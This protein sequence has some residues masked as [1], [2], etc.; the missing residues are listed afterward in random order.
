MDETLNTEN[1]ENIP[2]AAG[3]NNADTPEQ[4]QKRTYPK[5]KLPKIFRK[6]Y[7]EKALKRKIVKPI[8]IPLDKEF[9]QGI[10]VKDGDPKK[11]GKF[12]VPNDK[13]FSKKEIS[14][15]RTLA[16]DIQSRKGRFMLLPFAAVIGFF[17]LLCMLFTA[18]KNPLLK[19]ALTYAA[20]EAVGAKVDIGSVNLKILDAELTI[21]NV[22]VGN[23]KEVMKN[24]AQFDKLDV[25]FNLAQAL[26]GKFD[27]KNLEVTGI[28]LNTNRT[29]SCELPESRKKKTEEKPIEDSAFMNSLKAS[30]QA[31]LNDLQTQAVDLLGGSDVNSIVSNL[32]SQLK[33]L[34]TAN[35]ARTQMETLVTKWQGK[36]DEIK[37]QIENYSA[38]VKKIQNI[39]TSKLS[40]PAVIQEYITTIQGIVS[41]TKA[42]SE[43]AKS[44]KNEI[45]ADG[46]GVKDLTKSVTDSVKADKDMIKN[47]LSAVVDTVK[48]AKQL[49]NNALETVACNMLGEYYPYVRQGINMAEQL[50]QNSVVQAAMKSQPKTTEKKKGSNRLKGTDFSFGTTNPAFLIENALVSG[51]GFEA[52][53]KEITNDQ[54]IR[55]KTTTAT[56]TLS[57]A[58]ISHAANLVLDTRSASSEPLIKLGYTGDGIKAIFNGLNVAT[59]SG[60]PSLEG[61]AKVSLNAAAGS[62]FLNAGGSVDLTPIKLTTDGFVS[63]MITKYYQQ[64]LEAIKTML[65]GFNL[66]FTEAKGLDLKLLGD[67]ADKFADSLKAIVAGLGNEAK[68]KALKMLNDEINGSSNEYLAKAKEFIGLEDDINLANTNLSDMRAILEKKEQELQDRI[69]ELGKNKLQGV[70]EEQL[71]NSEAASG[72]SNAAA[73]AASKLFNKFKK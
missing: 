31:A 55:G 38:S 18:V 58:G 43:S 5:E 30:G 23:K 28:A 53:I 14:R 62:G 35:A 7:S 4:K 27:A 13:I 17:A 73:D 29:V 52:N 47:R 41:E 2:A 33:S 46:T 61:L 60:V 50:K 49:L 57:L 32:R 34:D 9:L 15:L 37:T 11:A 69:T 59:K 25:H 6:A 36:P 67:F 45:M 63:E 65:I 8:A 39:N 44:L 19:K 66:D 20:E 16:K 48:N 40:D 71:G 70:L 26:R 64:A 21:K 51:E 10:F 72:I 42:L 12:A 22:A 1:Q 56:G 3:E 24:I 54:N 68:N